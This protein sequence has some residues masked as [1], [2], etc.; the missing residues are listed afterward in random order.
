MLIW[1]N[2]EQWN[3]ELNGN[4]L[5]TYLKWNRCHP[6]GVFLFFHGWTDM[7]TTFQGWRK[8]EGGLGL[9]TFYSKSISPALTDWTTNWK[10]KKSSFIVLSCKS[11][12]AF[13]LRNT[14]ILTLYQVCEIRK[15]KNY[16]LF[17]WS[18]AWFIV[19][20][21]NYTFVLNR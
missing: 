8:V 2:S 9:H 21:K 20:F 10:K 1:L 17:T 11:N 19:A 15:G 4:L 12:L 3:V 14:T 16:D 18:R 7:H 13:I 5:L 6:F